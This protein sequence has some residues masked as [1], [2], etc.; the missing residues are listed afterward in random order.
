M[1]AKYDEDKDG[2]LNYTEFACFWDIPLFTWIS[3]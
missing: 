1:I 3:H 2:R